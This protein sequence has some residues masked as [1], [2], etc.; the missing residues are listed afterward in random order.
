M[1]SYSEGSFDPNK[2]KKKGTFRDCL[3]LRITGHF[4]LTARVKMTEEE[5]LGLMISKPRGK[6]SNS[7]ISRTILK[8]LGTFCSRETHG[9]KLFNSSISCLTLSFPFP[10]IN[11]KLQIKQQVIRVRHT[12]SP[13]WWTSKKIPQRL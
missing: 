2:V 3:L 4:S 9:Y 5:N 6:K 11:I 1:C 7:N 8:V 13:R 12:W 10:R